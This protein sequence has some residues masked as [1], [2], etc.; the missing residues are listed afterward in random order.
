MSDRRG[1]FCAFIQCSPLGGKNIIPPYGRKSKDRRVALS[2][3][4]LHTWGTPTAGIEPATIR[5]TAGGSTT[6]LS[7][8]TVS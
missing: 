2:P 7:R 1:G 4:R 3:V 6:E 8:K 5:L